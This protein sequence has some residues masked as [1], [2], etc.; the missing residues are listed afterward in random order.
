M[1]FTLLGFPLYQP[2]NVSSEWRTSCYSPM[3]SWRLLEM[4]R[5][6]VM[7][8]LP[9][10]A[11]TWTST[12]TSRGTP[13]VAMY[14]TTSWKSLGLS[15]SSRASATSTPSTRYVYNKVLDR[16]AGR[17]GTVLGI[18]NWTIYQHRVMNKVT[19]HSQPHYNI[20]LIGRYCLEPQIQ[21]SHG[22]NWSGMWTPT[23]S[24]VKVAHQE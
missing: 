8:T 10:L 16:Q 11:S 18:E 17:K 3:P 9:A 20:H 5:P 14:R 24:S 21:N 13:L 22:W 1:S 7:T 19:F 12:L 2:L 4:P 15:S 6:I 23:I